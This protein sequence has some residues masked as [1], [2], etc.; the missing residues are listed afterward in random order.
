MER[1]G[2]F[3][4][5]DEEAERTARE[6]ARSVERWRAEK[7]PAAAP[8]APLPA[9]HTLAV[10]VRLRP[11]LERERAAGVDEAHLKPLRACARLLARAIARDAR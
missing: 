5:P 2:G 4:E 10:C 6:L 3:G 1:R 9:E 7:A 8:L 11:V